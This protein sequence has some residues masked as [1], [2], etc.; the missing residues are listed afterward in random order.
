MLSTTIL[1]R[2]FLH[3][4]REN[5]MTLADPNPSLSPQEVLSFYSGTYPAL[6]TAKIEGP[7]IADDAVQYR[8]QTT[9]GTKG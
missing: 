4:V 7:E 6:T 9:L 2:V 3:K 8:F 1:K 5:E